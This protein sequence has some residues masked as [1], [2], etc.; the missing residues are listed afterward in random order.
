MKRLF[1]RVT[2]QGGMIMNIITCKPLNGSLLHN[3]NPRKTIRVYRNKSDFRKAQLQEIAKHVWIE[4]EKHVQH[5]ESQNI[6]IEEITSNLDMTREE[7]IRSIS[8]SA[9]IEWIKKYAEIF[10]IFH[11]QPVHSMPDRVDP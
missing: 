1:L 3:E 2:T 5:L 10:R 6:S 4:V 7:Y 11:W 9:A 8:N